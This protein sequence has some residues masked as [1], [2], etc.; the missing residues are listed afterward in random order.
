MQS[1]LLLRVLS[2]QLPVRLM[3]FKSSSGITQV[4]AQFQLL[5]WSSFT[6]RSGAP[7]LMVAKPL[8]VFT[9]GAYCIV[10]MRTVAAADSIRRRRSQAL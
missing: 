10:G 7:V 3:Q 9:P 6:V 5:L 1:E 2:Q 4:G 8:L